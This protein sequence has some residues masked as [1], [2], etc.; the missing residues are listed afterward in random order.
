MAAPEFA[1]PKWLLVPGAAL[2]T[3]S[4]AGFFG[5]ARVLGLDD[6]D[7]QVYLMGGNA[8]RHGQPVYDQVMHSDYGSGYFTYPPITVLVFG[9]LS[10]L[11]LSKAHAIILV[12]AVAALVSIV[13]LTMRMI[14][15]RP[16]AGLI[17]ATLAI[18]GAVVWLQPVY[19][20]LVQGQINLFIVFLVIA[21]FAFDGRRRWPTGV[22][23]GVAAAVKIVPG[24]FILY[25]LLNRRFRAAVT[26][27]VTWAVL[28]ALAFAAAW[29]DSVQF[30]FR[31]TFADS[32]RVASPLT[33][34]SVYNQSIHGIT[35]RLFG[36]HGGDLAWFPLAAIVGI[37]GLALAIV[38]SRA[39][40]QL[41]GVLMCALTGLLVSPL[42]WHEHWVY[43]VPVLIWL[44]DVARRLSRTAPVLAG[45]LPALPGLPFMMWPQP[46]GGPG[47][48]GPASILSP[49]R[50]LW[51]DKG[52][53]N[54]VVFLAGT[55][56]V[57]VG[58]LVMLVTA[59]V[60]RHDFRG[61][62]PRPAVGGT[63]GV[64]EARAAAPDG[65]ETSRV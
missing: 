43:I 13:W 22:L 5:I 14:G 31:G 28:T 47:Q 3:A 40:G 58:L 36:Q 25:L 53:H 18:A 57:A 51:E 65:R 45:A 30:W 2:F 62:R 38:A 42:T 19:D 17:G 52:N 20:T 9:P 6:Y 37:G 11:S 26:A 10:Y 39:A 49:A 23:I 60:L 35:V 24:I 15:A 54:P 63:A 56:Y 46:I 55:A 7:L 21:D 50:N 4:M 1:L 27:G 8:Y 48:V 64:P 16:G 34:G 12:L 33:P 41:A 59:W 29:S 44:G 61:G 32:T